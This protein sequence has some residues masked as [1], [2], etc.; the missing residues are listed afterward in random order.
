MRRLTLLL[1]CFLITALALPAMAKEI[2]GVVVDK[3]TN[4]PL[5]GA[6]VFIRGTTL[7]AATDINGRFSFSYEPARSFN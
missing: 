4:A 3:K 1:C 6:N 2:K 5:A 7:G